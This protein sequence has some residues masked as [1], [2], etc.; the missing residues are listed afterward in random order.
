M[1]RISLRRGANSLCALSE[2]VRSESTLFVVSGHIKAFEY[3]PKST[4]RYYAGGGAREDSEGGSRFNSSNPVTTPRRRCV[5]CSR[6]V[7]VRRIYAPL[8]LISSNNKPGREVTK[9]ARSQQ[10]G[11]KLYYTYR[12]GITVHNDAKVMVLHADGGAA[13][14]SS[15]SHVGLLSGPPRRYLQLPQNS[16]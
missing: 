14:V 3:E 6:G 11:C 1:K 9:G 7:I 8:K 2:L 5:S 15:D 10:R 4:G 13:L 16:P 12:A